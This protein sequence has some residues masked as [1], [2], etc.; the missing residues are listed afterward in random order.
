MPSRGADGR[1]TLFGRSAK[2]AAQDVAD[3]MTTLLPFN[4]PDAEFGRLLAKLPRLRA[5]AMMA[6]LATAS[7]HPTR[8]I[9]CRLELEARL[10]RR[11][12]LPFGGVAEW[13]KALVLKTSEVNASQGSNPCP[14]ANNTIKTIGY[15]TRTTIH[16]TNTKSLNDAT[17]Q[18][19]RPGSSAHSI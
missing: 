16:T 12:N 5:A 7:P 17:W 14:S 10:Q 1:R 9:R 19:L 6:S 15:M 2:S 11:G 3:A 8:P 18:F 13:S 4:Q